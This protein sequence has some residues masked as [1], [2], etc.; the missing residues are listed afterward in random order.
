MSTSKVKSKS[1][2]CELLRINFVQLVDEFS[3]IYQ[4]DPMLKGLSVWF[5]NYDN[6]VRH[7]KKPYNEMMLKFINHVYPYSKQITACDEEY[8]EDNVDKL[9]GSELG[10]VISIK[11]YMFGVDGN[12]HPILHQDDKD[13]IWKYFNIF[14]KLMEKYIAQDPSSYH[15]KFD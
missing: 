12:G 4:H 14:V 5:Q 6:E 7:G 15:K 1:E 9:F 8:F 11:K 13:T 10:Y 2:L 3:H